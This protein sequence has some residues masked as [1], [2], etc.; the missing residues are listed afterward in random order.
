LRAAVESQD[1][2]FFAGNTVFHGSAPIYLDRFMQ[3][4]IMLPGRLDRTCGTAHLSDSTHKQYARWVEQFLRF[5]RRAEGSWRMPAELRGPEAEAFLTHLAVERRLSESSQN[6]AICSPV[7]LYETV[8]LDELGQTT[9]A[10]SGRC[11]RRRRRRWYHAQS[12]AS[13]EA[14]ARA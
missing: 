9:W 8:L 10:R 11:D 12:D 14:N 7:F 1:T 13:R 3:N 6:Q 5:H 4:P 2:A